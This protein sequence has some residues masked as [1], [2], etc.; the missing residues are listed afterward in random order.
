MTQRETQM[1][2]ES[3]KPAKEIIRCEVCVGRKKILGFGGFDKT[4]HGCQG[5]GWIEKP[6]DEEI[7]AISGDISKPSK[8]NKAENTTVKIKKKPGRKKKV[9]MDILQVSA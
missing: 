5:I 8:T 7:K 4:C 2:E 3:T 1:T 6:R 9:Q